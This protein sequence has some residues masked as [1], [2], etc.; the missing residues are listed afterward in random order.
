MITHHNRSSSSISPGV[1]NVFSYN[2]E[3]AEKSNRSQPRA[4]M[5]RSLT[6][7][8]DASIYDY[9]KRSLGDKCG[10]QPRRVIQNNRDRSGT[11][12]PIPFY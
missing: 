7:D 12:S 1:K 10:D 4:T 9:Y 6:E 8:D 2:Q 3:L 11:H 5:M